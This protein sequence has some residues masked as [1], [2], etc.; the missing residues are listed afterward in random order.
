MQMLGTEL[1]PLQEQGAALSAGLEED[2]KDLGPSC[3][4]EAEP[5]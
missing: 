1:H 2:V 5:V 3:E 4:Q